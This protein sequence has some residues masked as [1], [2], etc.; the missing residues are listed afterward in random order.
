M[1]DSKKIVKTAGNISLSKIA[2]LIFSFVGM[3]L[4]ALW[5]Y[6]LTVNNM[7]IRQSRQE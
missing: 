5:V 1:S 7:E 3:A 6:F 2:T 4:L